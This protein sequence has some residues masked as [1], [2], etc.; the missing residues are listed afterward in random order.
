MGDADIAWLLREIAPFGTLAIDTGELL[1]EARWPQQIEVQAG[2]HFVRPRYE[3]I[4]NG[5]TQPP[6]R[7]IAHAH[8]APVD[9]TPDQRLP[10][11]PNHPRP[12]LTLPA[13]NLPPA[14]PP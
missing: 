8:V 14:P 3:V 6:R 12:A 7:R 2:K 4:S 5:T 10:E 13:P 1:P 9:L 11:L